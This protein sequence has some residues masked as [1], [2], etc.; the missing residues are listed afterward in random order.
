[1][2]LNAIAGMTSGNVFCKGAIAFWK[3]AMTKIETA[4][5]L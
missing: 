1:M 2:L 4:I 5:A 3:G